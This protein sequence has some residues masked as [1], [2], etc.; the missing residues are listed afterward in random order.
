[1]TDSTPK[2]AQPQ[3]SVPVDH[4]MLAKIKSAAQQDRRSVAGY[5]RL[6]L[7]KALEQQSEAAA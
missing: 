5:A 4:E 2:R 6:V 7:E 3:I 1:M